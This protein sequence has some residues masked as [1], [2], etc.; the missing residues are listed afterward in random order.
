MKKIAFILVVALLLLNLSA[1]A[2][3]ADQIT[4]PTASPSSLQTTE[5]VA[6]STPEEL[7]QQ[8]YDIGS[9]LRANGNYP[10]TE[11]SKGDKGFEVKAL[12]TRLAELGYYNKAVVDNFGSGTYNALRAFEKEN[13]LKVNGI[14]SVEDQ[15]VLFGNDALPY[16]GSKV[17][18][19][20]T[21]G[22]QSNGE[23]DATSGA[24]S[25]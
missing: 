15:I 5:T 20:K 11:L 9:Q 7:L 8:W 25:K 1:F 21:D 6:A 24:T 13:G 23:S 4:D 19:S 22:N 14:A 12:Q 3:T 2:Q 10:F 18:A 17:A 16:T